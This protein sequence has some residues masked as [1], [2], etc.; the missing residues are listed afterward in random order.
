MNFA[1]SSGRM[2]PNN[3]FLSLALALALAAPAAHAALAAAASF[4]DKVDNAAAI[5]LGKCI[6]TESRF[7]STHRWIVTYS[8]F[9][10]EKSFKGNPAAEITLIT[11][12]GTV[13]NL[14]QSS[15][16]IP[17]FREGDE[18]VVFVKN[19]PVGPTVL[20]FDQGTYDVRSDERGERVVAPVPTNLV[21][22]DTQRGMAVAPADEPRTLQQFETAV[23][24]SMRT[25]AER[26]QKMAAAPQVKQPPASIVDTLAQNKLLVALALVGLALA[27]W[28]LWRR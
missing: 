6:R 23:R 5:I 9:A 20:Y 17:A 2:T 18:H 1:S 15:V 14:H 10:V 27:A 19:T 28:Q 3:R 22:V 11:P 16:G 24:D 8:T 12:G 7:D 4:D 26:K 13:G 25:A 21:T